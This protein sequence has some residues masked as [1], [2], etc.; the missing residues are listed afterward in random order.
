MRAGTQ[1]VRSLLWRI[2]RHG[3]KS[4]VSLLLIGFVTTCL[5]RLAPGF[6]TD[7]RE[8]DPRFASASV[9]RE[10]APNPIVTY[11]QL[12]RDA[13]HGDFG[14]SNSLNRPVRELL[15]QRYSVS[16]EILALGWGTG[17]LAAMSLASLGGVLSSWVPSFTGRTLGGFV[18]CIPSALLAYLCYLVNAPAFLIV[19][20]VVFSRV[21]RVVDNLI[22]AVRKFPHVVAAKACG[23]S[24]IR[25]FALHVLSSTWPELIA[26][27][28][29]SA[30]IAI[31]ATIPAEA[32]CDQPGIGQLAW[33]AALSRDLPLLV[34][35]TFVIGFITIF[36][37][38]SGDAIIE[39]RRPA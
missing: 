33:K 29:T 35:I 39:L 31:G 18:L 27:A 30:A 5:V 15:A 9:M 34:T 37:N 2:G 6:G 14:F 20:L 11:L 13:V 26:L 4:A 16:L 7:E 28:G 19:A 23:L 24:D 36:F 25:I 21:F 38:R 8:L 1:H 22:Q 32:L 17:W 3:L 12:L 10:D